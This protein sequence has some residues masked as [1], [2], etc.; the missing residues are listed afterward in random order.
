MTIG[1][2]PNIEA[3]RPFG[4]Y[5]TAPVEST[6]GGGTFNTSGPVPGNFEGGGVPAPGRTGDREFEGIEIDMD[7]HDGT[8]DIGQ[9]PSSDEEVEVRTSPNPYVQLTYVR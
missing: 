9:D 4:L 1:P 8:A 2:Q 7:K 3:P 5:P 6:R